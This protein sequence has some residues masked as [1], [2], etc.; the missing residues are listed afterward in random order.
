MA[1]KLEFVLGRVIGRERIEFIK[2][3]HTEEA[4]SVLYKHLLIQSGL[5]TKYMPFEMGDDGQ[6]YPMN[7]LAMIIQDELEEA[8]QRERNAGNPGRWVM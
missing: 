5:D 8:M 6:Y 7:E 2:G 4:I 3:C 1:E